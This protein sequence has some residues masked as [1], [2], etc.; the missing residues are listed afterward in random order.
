MRVAGDLLQASRDIHYRIKVVF[1]EYGPKLGR[2]TIND[3]RSDKSIEAENLVKKENGAR[4]HPK[5]RTG[6]FNDAKAEQRYRERIVR[7]HQHLDILGQAKKL[8]L[9]NI[10]ISLRVGEYV[11]AVEKPDEPS[12]NAVE[13]S[14]Q[15]RSGV[16]AADAALNLDPPRL[17]ILGDPGS[18]KTTLLKCD[19]FQDRRERSGLRRL[20][21]EN[22]NSG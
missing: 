9:D 6:A 16:I 15:Q 11:P 20:V 1:Q 10:F 5:K 8:E 22:C 12:R 4:K 2:S 17:A 21:A 3:V 14:T 7:E 18:G 19:G 13:A